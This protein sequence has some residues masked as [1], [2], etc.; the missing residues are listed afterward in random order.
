MYA[1]CRVVDRVQACIHEITE[2]A[3]RRP[4]ATMRRSIDQVIA[5][6]VPGI[7][8]FVEVERAILVS[9]QARVPEKINRW[10][11]YHKETC[12]YRAICMSRNLHIDN[13]GLFQIVHLEIHRLGRSRLQ[14]CFVRFGVSYCVTPP[15]SSGR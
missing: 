6:N 15:I 5:C 4:R 2:L 7:F 9:G 13:D 1:C 3:L 11:V 14:P 12:F 10:M 8:Q